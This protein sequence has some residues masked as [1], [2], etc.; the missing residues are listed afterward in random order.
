MRKC[1]EDC[2]AFLT[3]CLGVAVPLQ[4]GILEGKT[5]TGP[6]LMLDALRQQAP[7][8]NWV[9]KR[10]VRDGKLWT[11]GALLNGTDLMHAFV[12]EFWG[13]G[14]EKLATYLSRTSAWPTRDVDYKDVPWQL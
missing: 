14:E 1:W 9:E 7:A 6:R 5:A 4:A 3:V 13:G 12:H 8:T 11:S 10:W 2:V